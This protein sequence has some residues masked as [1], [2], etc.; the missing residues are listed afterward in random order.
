MSKTADNS[1]PKTEE[2]GAEKAGST[3]PW[4]DDFDAERAWTLVQNLRSEKESLK[5]ELATERQKSQAL[6][7]NESDGLKELRTRAEAAEER[8]K[9]AERKLNVATV[10]RDFPAL[11][12]FEDLLTGD[13]V[14]EI[15][16]KAERLASIGD[17][18]DDA[19]DPDKGDPKPDESEDEGAKGGSQ[20]DPLPG[21]PAPDLVPGH[22]GG[23]KA[24]FDP[25]AI[26]KAARNAGRF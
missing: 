1:T 4:G 11:A 10:L 6:E 26:A 7:A 20:E 19:E 18:K 2:V 22:G 25:D 15:K 5:G 12:D 23:E 16:A 24:P 21:R 13:T 9:E 8:A 3:P 14:E 17:K